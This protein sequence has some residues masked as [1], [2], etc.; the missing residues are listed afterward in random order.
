MAKRGN[1]RGSDYSDYKAGPFVAVVG[2]EMPFDLHRIVQDRCTEL[3]N[4]QHNTSVHLSFSL[5]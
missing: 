2:R 1:I 3:S 4:A 5:G